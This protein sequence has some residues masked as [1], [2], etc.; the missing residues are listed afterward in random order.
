LERGIEKLGEFFK[1]CKYLLTGTTKSAYIIFE[2]RK[3]T[4]E[5][6]FMGFIGLTGFMELRL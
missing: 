2:E 6:G 3:R 4:S 5:L 1:K